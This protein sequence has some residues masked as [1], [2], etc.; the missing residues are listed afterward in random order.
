MKPLPGEGALR[1]HP[2]QRIALQEDDVPRR[3]VGRWNSAFHFHHFVGNRRNFRGRLRSLD[4]LQRRRGGR[5]GAPQGA[6]RFQRL[7]EA[8]QR[9]ELV[10]VLRAQDLLGAETAFLEEHV[11]VVVERGRTDVAGEDEIEFAFPALEQRGDRL[12]HPRAN[13]LGQLVAPDLECV[14][15][16][17]GRRRCVRVTRFLRRLH[18]NDSAR[19]EPG[20]EIRMLGRLRVNHQAVAKENSVPAALIDDLQHA[21]PPAEK[22]DLDDVGQGE[23]FEATEKTHSTSRPASGERRAA[24]GRSKP[25][26]LLAACRSPFT[27]PNCSVSRCHPRSR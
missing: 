6:P 23:I 21:G 1:G 16:R 3:G 8:A 4:G 15:Q 24:S 26:S 27:T 22:D 9:L 14:D 25:R 18:R 11:R 10:A 13:R 20:D 2:N 5:R 17:C 19:F 12:Q 7:F